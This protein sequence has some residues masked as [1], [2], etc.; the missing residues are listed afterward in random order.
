[1]DEKP[2]L[3]YFT[4]NEADQFTF[5]RIPKQL[6]TNSYFRN[7][8]TDAKVLYGLM[9]DRISLSIKN[10]WVDEQNRVYIYFSV[11]D[12]MEYLNC[13][14]NK[15][16]QLLSE[17]DSERGIGL[18]EK[19]RQGQGKPSVIY[20]KNF[21]IPSDS[22]KTQKESLEKQPDAVSEVGKTNF[23]KSENQTSGSLKNQPLEVGKTNPNKNKWNNTDMNQTERKDISSDL[24]VSLTDV[25]IKKIR[26]TVTDSN[27]AQKDNMS[28][29]NL[30]KEIQKRIDYESL[31]QRYP[32]QEEMING[33][34][35]L[36]QEIEVSQSENIV[37]SS[38]RLPMQLVRERFRKLRYDHVQYVIDCMLANTSKVRNIR[39]Y[40]LAALFNAP[41]TIDG[42]YQAEVNHD[43]PELARR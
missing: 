33:I 19:R 36:M 29:E 38:S 32:F 18:I 2:I 41:A 26:S 25:P 14:K 31:K 6:F 7:L 22:G 21:F 16:V 5:Y 34:C 20:V 23:K 4:G 1:M 15:A 3:K 11:E 8:S 30:T 42:Y 9:L 39:K 12:T 28:A 35:D 10:H 24:I 43:M 17:L 27:G 13:R 37:I 40:M